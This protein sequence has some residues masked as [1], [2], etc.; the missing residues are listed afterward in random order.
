MKELIL[1]PGLKGELVDSPMPLPGPNELL[2]RVVVAAVNPKD[3]KAS[4]QLGLTSNPADDM[5]GIVEA[6]GSE[7][8]E[9]KQGD[10]VAALHQPFTPHGTF[11]EFSLAPADTAFKISDSTGF[12]EAAA[13]PL[14]AMTAGLALHRRLGLPA[15][16]DMAANESGTSARGPVLIYGAGAAVGAYAVQL[17]VRARLHPIIAIAG[18]SKE[19]VQTIIDPSQGDVVLDYRQGPDAVVAQAKEALGGKALY[20]AFDCISSNGSD[21]FVGRI[22]HA[23]E[24]EKCKVAVVVPR[25]LSE[26]SFVQVPDD[27]PLDPMRGIP[28]D[29]TVMW[30]N[31][32]S[33]FETENDFGYIFFRYMGKGIAEGWL[34]AVPQ[35]IVP[36][37][38]DGVSQALR[39]IKDGVHSATKY[40]VRI[41][42]AAKSGQ[43]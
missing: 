35:T 1:S 32:G 30:T 23:H 43:K 34:K 9:F 12:E 36:G 37:G 21:N 24:P 41:G 16:W 18:G 11:A 14:A 13:I 15:P 40:V 17:A 28:E 20:H 27:L 39:D 31:L 22:I 2:I 25:S 7:V 29:V 19:Y 6:V 5:S 4:E 26:V 8:F 38:L 3:W 33:V 42:D 10:R